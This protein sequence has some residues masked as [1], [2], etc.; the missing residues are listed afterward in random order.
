MLL[1]AMSQSDS[2]RLALQ[3]TDL[4]S[5]LETVCNQATQRVEALMCVANVYSE[6]LAVKGGGEADDER[7]ERM[8]TLFA[9]YNVA[10]EV[11][12]QLKSALQQFQYGEKPLAMLRRLL[13]A[14]RNLA[15]DERGA[16]Q[17]LK[18][19]V[20]VQLMATLNKAERVRD[21]A[22]PADVAIAADALQ[23][24][25]Y[26]ERLRDQLAK[27]NVKAAL[28]AAVQRSEDDTSEGGHRLAEAAR[29]A[30]AALDGKFDSVSQRLE[31]EGDDLTTMPHFNVFISHKR[32][33]AQDFA[34]S[35]YALLS[36]QNY[37]CFLDVEALETIS[38]LPLI[39]A[40]CDALIFVLTDSILYSHWCRIELAAAVDAGVPVILITKEGARW[41]D[42]EGQ[43][44]CTFPPPEEIQSIEPASAQ[45]AFA[46][47]KAVQHSNEY[48]GEFSKKL[49]ER[50][51]ATVQ[52]NKGRCAA[53]LHLRHTREK[54]HWLHP[55]TGTRKW[56]S[57]GAKSTGSSVRPKRALSSRSRIPT[58]PRHRCNRQPAMIR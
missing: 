45:Q 47:S 48:Y 44:I 4:L 8:R 57:L 58:W 12:S 1:L 27:S 41:R 29:G 3:G 10:D 2:L 46:K 32:T 5:A 42:A 7:N 26:V 6:V 37:S 18:A 33:D 36:A 19:G 9:T 43:L 38:D 49:L 54:T 53:A 50:V 24:L 22:S 35:L 39:V 15:I 11:C 28:E 34:R 20:A 31:V 55:C 17:L 14:V 56:R 21:G 16:E 51:N 52:P 25:A 13:F 30:P 23:K 40:G